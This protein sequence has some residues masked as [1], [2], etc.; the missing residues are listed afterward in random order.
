L[1]YERLVR[2]LTKENLWLYILKMLL[3]KPDYPLGLKR[4]FREK[5]SFEPAGITFYTVLYR[6]KSEGLVTSQSEGGRTIYLCT[7]RGG[8]AL[9]MAVRYLE[10]TSE[11]LKP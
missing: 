3:E 4:R 10:T 11:K 5:F 8:E 6:L 9:R 7:E 1:A 2:K